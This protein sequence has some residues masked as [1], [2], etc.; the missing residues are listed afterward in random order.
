MIET[1]ADGAVGMIF[2]DSTAF[3][4]SAGGRMVLDEFICDPE[5][6]RIRLGLVSPEGSSLTLPARSRRPAGLSIDTPVAR[7]RGAARGGGTGILTLAALTF[8]VIDELQAHHP[9]AF[10]DDDRIKFSD[11]PFGALEI[12]NKITGEKQDTWMTLR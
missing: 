2:K 7:I 8:A 3:H 1:A 11:M 9:Y 6:A 10:L 12:E 5:G 4:L